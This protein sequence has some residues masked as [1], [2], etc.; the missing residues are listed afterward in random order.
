MLVYR[1]VLWISECWII[2]EGFGKGFSFS[3]HL[4][5]ENEI[6]WYQNSPWFLL[7]SSLSFSSSAFVKKTFS[8]FWTQF[9]SCD[10]VQLPSIT[11]RIINV[12]K[13]LVTDIKATWKKPLRGLTHQW[14]FTTCKSWNHPPSTPPQNSP[15]H[16]PEKWW[17]GKWSLHF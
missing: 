9:V 13:W 11:W 10:L 16:A 17:V 7:D 3:K 12:S 1:S 4:I 8:N 15:A 2:L 5:H 6:T 14:L